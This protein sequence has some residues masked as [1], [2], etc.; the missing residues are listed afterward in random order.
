MLN[1]PERALSELR[2]GERV[3]TTITSHHPWGFT[4]KI[5]G[6]EPVGASLDVIRRGRE[7]GV[8]QLA[9]ELPT[10]GSTVELVIGELRPWHHEPWTWVDLTSDPR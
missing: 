4:A 6:Y 7:P 1:E 9:Q 3:Q 8:R 5:H 2:T 10:V